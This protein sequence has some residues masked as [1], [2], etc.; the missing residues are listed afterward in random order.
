MPFGFLSEPNRLDEVRVF[1]LLF[2]FVLFVKLKVSKKQV[3]FVFCF[4][5]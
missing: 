1:C 5:F 3:G 4:Y 2:G